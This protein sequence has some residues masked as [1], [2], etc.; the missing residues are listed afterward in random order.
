MKH[1]THTLNNF[2]N[3][4]ESYMNTCIYDISCMYS[5]YL[6]QLLYIDKFFEIC[7]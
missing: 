6:R 7:Y 2:Q 4:R 3:K 5:E 1:F